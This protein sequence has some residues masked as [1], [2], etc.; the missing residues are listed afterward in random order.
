LSDGGGGGGCFI[1]TAAYGSYLDPH[2]EALRDFRDKYLATNSVGRAFV[3]LYERYSPPVAALIARHKSLKVATR[4]VLTPLIYGI[5]YPLAAGASFLG[6]LILTG[7][8]LR[9]KRQRDKGA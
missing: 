8:T 2:V 3:G 1:A 7:R 9:K 5:S 4:A 6:T